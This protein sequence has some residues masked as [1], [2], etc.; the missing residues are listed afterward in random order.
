MNKDKVILDK[1]KAWYISKYKQI[2]LNFNTREN[3]KKYFDNVENDWKYQYGSFI[4][5]HDTVIFAYFL[6]FNITDT[7]CTTFKVKDLTENID[8]IYSFGYFE[9]VSKNKKT[10]KKI[11]SVVHNTEYRYRYFVNGGSFISKDGEYRVGMISY[12]SVNEIKRKPVI[13]NLFHDI[14]DYV[15]KSLFERNMVLIK[16]YFYPTNDKKNIEIELEYYS[17]ELQHELFAIT[18]FNTIYK[19]YLNIVENHLNENY[20]KIMFKYAKEDITFLNILIKK[21]KKNVIEKLRFMS[22]HVFTNTNNTENYNMA[23]K[24]GQKIIPLTISEIQ[25]PFSIEYKPWREYLISAKLSDYV[26]NNVSPGFFI[27][28]TWLYIKNSRKGL[29]DN[30]IQYEKMRTSELA[31]QITELLHRSQLF[32]HENIGKS[33]IKKGKRQVNTFFSK[34]FKILYDKIQD[35]IEYAKNEIIMSNVAFC[36]MSEY[37]GRTLWD[38]ISL[39]ES[40]PYYNNLIGKP[41][42]ESGYKYFAKYMFELCYNLLCINSISGIIHGDL[43]LNNLTLKALLYKQLKNISDI[44]NPSVLYVIGDVNNQYIFQ[45]VG[46]CL[47][48]IDFSRSIILPEKINQLKNNFL[49]KSHEIINNIKSFQDEQVNRMLNMY[50]QYVPDHSLNTDDLFLLFKN[51]FNASFKLCT[52]LDL[53]SVVQKLLN[54]F[55]S[56]NVKH[57][58]HYECIK[59]LQNLYNSSQRFFTEEINKLLNY[60][61]YEKVVLEMDWPIKMIIESCFSNFIINNNIGDIIDIYNINNELTYSINALSQ[62]P[63]QL[64]VSEYNKKNNK[65]PTK[66]FIEARKLYEKEKDEGFKT[67][68]YIAIRQKEKIL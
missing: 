54:L 40:S 61:D 31:I 64:L 48:L 68:N 15:R 56:S 28:G 35:P 59:L 2:Y 7:I 10:Y 67:I 55:K 19:H 36:M 18:W 30:D 60:K 46:Y 53:F 17:Y 13:Q 3:V 57:K 62:F 47:C 44:K 23:T 65:D 34:K 26:I 52:T 39:S 50:L 66:F 33:T 25:N 38:V 22:N 11:S 8:T 49:P 29:F 21:Y 43:H 45:T 1:R 41:F 37:V 9:R 6:N 63:P 5:L 32:T 24:V 4:R 51:K 16:E 42:T 27:T 20:K 14:K 58:P 12:H